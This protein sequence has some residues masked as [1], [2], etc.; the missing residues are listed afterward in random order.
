MILKNKN[1]SL[2]FHFKET[3]KNNK[4]VILNYLVS[5]FLWILIFVFCFFFQTNNFLL[6]TKNY[7]I[8]LISCALCGFIIPFS[9]SSMQGVTRNELA[10]PTTLGFLPLTTTSLVIYL[11]IDKAFP[12]VLNIYVEYFINLFLAI[13]SIGIIYLIAKKSKKKFFLILMGLMFGVLIGAINSLLVYLLPN[14]QISYSPFLGNL[15]IRTD[16]IYIYS[17]MAFNIVG[18]LMILIVGRKITIIQ[19]NDDLASSLGINVKRIF[20][21]SSFGSILIS[22]GSTLLIG[23]IVG[24]AIVFPIIVR[25]ILRKNNFYT[26]SF[27]SSIWTS[28]LLIVS[29]MLNYRFGYGLNFFCMFIIAPIFLYVVSRKKF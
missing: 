7:L 29:C 25:K 10:G 20:L 16:E 19:N 24:I 27:L 3:N 11:L 5:V 28:S 22:I 14:F 17:S 9:G 8:Q 26:C 21:I 13:F 23:S 15:Q 12:N 6:P 18:L 1:I 4:F 2:K